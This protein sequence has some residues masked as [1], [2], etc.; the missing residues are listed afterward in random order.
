MN[1]KKAAY[2]SGN[3]DYLTIES[4]DT[5]PPFFMNIVSNGDN[6]IFAGSNATL[7]AGRQ[8][9]DHALFPYETADKLLKHPLSAGS[10]TWIH[11]EQGGQSILWEP[12]IDQNPNRPLR[13]SLHKHIH[14]SALCYEEQHDTCNLNYKW[15]WTTSEKHGIVRLST[16]ENTGVEPVR[17]RLLDGLNRLL[18]AGVDQMLFQNYS[19]LAQGYMRHERLSDHPMGIYTLN[20]P[21]SDRA[22]PSEQLRVS[23]AACLGETPKAL[24]LSTRQIEAFRQGKAIENEHEIRGEFGAFLA[25]FEFELA[26]GEKKEWVFVSDTHLDHSAIIE[27]KNALEDKEALLQE[28]L[29]S[30]ANEQQGLELRIAQADG[31]QLTQDKTACIH[32]FANVLYNCMRGGT[33]TDGYHFPSRDFKIFL[34]ENNTD[35][36]TKYAASIDQMSNEITLSDLYLFA[37]NA[38]DEQLTR[39]VYQYLPITFSRRHGDPSRPWN[40]FD[41][42]IKNDQGQPVYAY[43]GNWRDIFQNWESLSQSF[44]QYITHMIT[45][46]LNA[47]T[48]DGYNPYRVTRNGIDW[49]TPEPDDPWSNIGYWGDHQIIYLLRLLETA[50]QFYP[51]SLSEK[52]N[53]TIYAYADVPYRIASFEKICDNPRDTIAFATEAHDQLMNQADKLGADG[54]LIKDA[55]GQ[56]LQ[57]SLIEK[58]LIPLLAKLTNFVPGGGIWLNTQRPEWNDANNALAGYGLSMVTTYYIRR[59]LEFLRGV[60]TTDK[61]LDSLHLTAP[62]GTLIHELH[63]IFASQSTSRTLEEATAKYEMIA[64]LGKAGET[65]RVAIYAKSF[66]QTVSVSTAEVLA[67]IDDVLPHIDATIAANK[68]ADG[69]YHSYNL[70]SLQGESA[71][72][73]YLYPMLEGQVAVLSS[74]LLNGKEVADLY[75]TMRDSA[76]FREDLATYLLYPNREITPFLE[77]NVLSSSL[78]ENALVQ[79]LIADGDVSIVVVD[80]SGDLHFNGDV[81]NAADLQ[82]RLEELPSSI[83]KEIIEEGSSVLLE[84]WEATFNHHAFTGRSGTFFAFEGLGSVYWHMVSKLL[85]AVQENAH[86]D[87][88]ASERPEL[89]EAYD[90]VRNGLGFTKTPE[91]YGAYPT[92]PYSHSPSHVGAQQPGMT[93]QVKEEVLTRR[94]ELGASISNGCLTFTP[95]LV[96]KREFLEE[97]AL[98]S[99]YDQHNTRS[100]AEVPAGGIAFTVAQVPVVYMPASENAIEVTLQDGETEEHTGHTLSEEQSANL[101][102]REGLITKLTVKFTG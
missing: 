37:D 10:S 65:H 59:Y 96:H 11:V 86:S 98:F 36:E 93:G 27:R 57:V 38:N 82:V 9:P 78:K 49:E 55:S 33:F 20:A 85:L 48:A 26:P 76:L 18:P 40:R 4:I 64:A 22:E 54:K 2:V 71:Q 69:L 84:A 66:D 61:A 52:L 35:L 29:S 7:T 14:G 51:G 75:K 46:F 99:Y 13:R 15:E 39:L 21:I 5:L 79:K 43:Q 32:H 81:S 80:E 60:L 70:L 42:K 77:K 28:V 3:D 6:W 88:N 56:V 44:P 68:R 53:N 50:E 45:L 8:N 12:W 74:G 97:K 90:H 24:L 67:F 100:E 62:V 58:L 1:V 87:A 19:Y 34:Q 92:D 63:Q 31:L 23:Y 41:I 89:L 91:I 73:E 72:V 16:L 17:V 94:G 101:F 25:E 47:S 102:N 95:S 83:A 30:V